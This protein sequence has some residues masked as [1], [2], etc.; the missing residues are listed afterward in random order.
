MRI[1]PR[2]GILKRAQ[3][4]VTCQP[5]DGH[6]V[7]RK[8]RD[9]VRCSSN[10]YHITLSPSDNP[11]LSAFFQVN[12]IPKSGTIRIEILPF[13][14]FM[15][16]S[17]NETRFVLAKEK[18]ENLLWFLE[19]YRAKKT[20]LNKL[21]GKVS[22]KFVA[23]RCS[24]STELSNKR[25]VPSKFALYSFTSQNIQEYYDI[26]HLLLH[27]PSRS[28]ITH[29]SVALY[30][31]PAGRQFLDRVMEYKEWLWS[32]VPPEEQ[33]R[34][35]TFSSILLFAYGVRIPN[36]MDLYIHR[37]CEDEPLPSGFIN[38]LFSGSQ[39]PWIEPS[40]RGFGR[41]VKGGVHERLDTWFLK[42]W[43]QLAG[44]HSMAEMINDPRHHFYFMGLKCIS[45]KAD[46]VRRISRQRPAAFADLIAIKQKSRI[47]ELAPVTIPPLPTEYW[48]NHTL[49]KL[50]PE[51]Q[52]RFLRTTR[53]Y[54]RARYGVQYSIAALEKILACQVTRK[55]EEN[56]HWQISRIRESSPSERIKLQVRRAS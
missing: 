10:P 48:I 32:S 29:G 11:P 27:R 20:R 41:W 49:Q 6:L 33:W 37:N 55:P 26:A 43:P 40:C 7:G 31:T 13:D 36:D 3:T 21:K 23:V 35:M 56:S 14:Q 9:D 12:N 52:L 19:I 8:P 38:T 1:L 46:I 54:L 34:F 28:L 16:I 30:E 44:A 17:R 25:F 50:L 53:A 4:G 39:F 5:A 18:I 51:D 24:I 15:D 47:P 42:E 45:L 2:S 22:Q